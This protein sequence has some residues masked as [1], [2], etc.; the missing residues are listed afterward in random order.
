MLMI[1][2]ELLHPTEEKKESLKK[3]GKKFLIFNVVGSVLAV[4]LFGYIFLRIANG[5][6]PSLFGQLTNGQSGINENLK[7]AQM[8][9][10]NAFYG[11][12]STTEYNQILLNASQNEN[13]VYFTG[14]EA[15]FTEATKKG[16]SILSEL[17]SDPSNTEKTNE[18]RAILE[19]LAAKYYPSIN[20]NSFTDEEVQGFFFYGSI[21]LRFGLLVMDYRY[22]P[23][24][25]KL[26][27]ILAFDSSNVGSK[28]FDVYTN[29]DQ[30]K[31]NIIDVC[32]YGPFG[33]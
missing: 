12:I 8:E 14:N 22:A 15:D 25:E 13:H 21:D 29:Y 19:P 11:T 23:S 2:D 33:L 31:M 30:V 3:F 32:N 17:S 7:A 9:S 10:R 27:E 28:L 16:V 26:D 4:V 5:S 6:N 1:I 18:L 24:Q 20:T